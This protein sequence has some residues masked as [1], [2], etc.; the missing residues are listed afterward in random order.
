MSFQKI[1]RVCSYIDRQGQRTLLV[2][3]DLIQH[4]CTILLKSNSNRSLVEDE[5]V[6]VLMLNPSTYH[7]L[8][9]STK[10]LFLLKKKIQFCDILIL[11]FSLF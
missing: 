6:T 2:F 11:L 8:S 1:N 3:K 5:R 4:S 9:S 7:S 10:H